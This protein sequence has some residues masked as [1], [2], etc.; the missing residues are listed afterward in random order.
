MGT[1]YQVLAKHSIFLVLTS[2]ETF[3]YKPCSLHGQSRSSKHLS[4]T[5]DY[6]YYYYYYYTIY[7]NTIAI[8]YHQLVKKYI[9]S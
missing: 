8:L 4:G 5:V 3:T 2:R 6:Y 9:S 1:S 7:K